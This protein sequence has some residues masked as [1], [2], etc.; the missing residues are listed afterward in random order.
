M[1]RT[2]G[3]IAPDLGSPEHEGDV[4]DFVQRFSAADLGDRTA[5]VF[6]L[7]RGDGWL[8]GS[9]CP[10]DAIRRLVRAGVVL[11]HVPIRHGGVPC[12]PLAPPWRAMFERMRAA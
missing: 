7:L 11:D 6:R 4:A 3:A 10:P 1:S 5:E 2:W 12:Y 9:A 8:T